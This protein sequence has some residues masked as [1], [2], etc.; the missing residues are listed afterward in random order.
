[1]ID[2]RPQPYHE[3]L[4]A[5]LLR[6]LSIA[7]VLTTLLTVLLIATGQARGALVRL[8]LTTY[9]AILWF[10]LGG[11]YVE[12]LYLN[13]LRM[14]RPAFHRHR[15]STR[16]GVWFIGGLPLG[17]GLWWTWTGLGNALPV[18][19]PWWWGMPAFVIVEFVV[20]AIRQALG[21]PN[22]WNGRE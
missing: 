10:P 8:W 12:L 15:R 22:F 14:R 17:L 16:I 1:M 9:P 6:T 13:V 11:H 5:T 19:P 4:G 2:Q 3:S 20:H 18:A 21:Y 7:F